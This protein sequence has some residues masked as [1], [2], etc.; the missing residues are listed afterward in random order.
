MMT[1]IGST[2]HVSAGEVADTLLAYQG[3][4]P[5]EVGKVVSIGR[6]GDMSQDVSHVLL[7]NGRTRRANGALDVGEIPVV[8]EYDAADA[9]YAIILAGA[10][11]QNVHVFKF[12]DADGEDRYLQG[13]IANLATSERTSSSIKTAEF[14]IRAQTGITVDP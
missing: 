2:L 3:V 7:K 14:T 9:G 1:Y 8:V 10:N 6:L 12:S 5:T 13:V 4:T 11:T